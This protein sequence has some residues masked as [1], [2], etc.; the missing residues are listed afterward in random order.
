V[1]ARESQKPAT[2]P[3]ARMAAPAS[4]VRVRGTISS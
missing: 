1:L 3:A 2:T 4:S